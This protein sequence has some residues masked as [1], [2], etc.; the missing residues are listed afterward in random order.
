[1]LEETYMLLYQRED[2]LHEL[3]RCIVCERED[4]HVE[5][6]AD[7]VDWFHTHVDPFY[8]WQAVTICVQ[9]TEKNTTLE[10]VKGKT[11]VK[12]LHE[13]ELDDALYEVIKAWDRVYGE[14]TPNEY[15]KTLAFFL[16]EKH[17]LQASGVLVEMMRRVQHLEK[18]GSATQL[19]LAD[20]LRSFVHEVLG[21]MYEGEQEI[22]EWLRRNVP[23][24]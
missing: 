20:S 10:Q 17:S 23:E 7:G 16:R 13:K 4:I 19:M 6:V 18:S 14:G 5:V 15:T 1:M 12:P 9:W 2:Q 8:L 3:L 21:W 22:Q 11:M 24:L